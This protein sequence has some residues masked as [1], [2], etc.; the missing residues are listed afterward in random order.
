MAPTSRT[1]SCATAAPPRVGE[2]QPRRIL[3]AL[4]AH[5]V[6]Y[7]LIGGLAGIARGSSYP[8]YDVDIAY[9]H[10][11]D[12]LER[13][14]SALRELGATLRGAPA[15]LPFVLD[16]KTLEAGSHFMFD[17]PF[18][19]LDILH[20]PD[21]RRRTDNWSRLRAPPC[22]SSPSRSGW[23]PSTTSSR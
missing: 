21:G 22:P 8:T 16:W 18:G 10:D 14:A 4:A 6:D 2:F 13:L 3:E 5:E 17:T 19:S 20:D 1:S 9:A 11:R 15:G 7:V 12:N 23:H